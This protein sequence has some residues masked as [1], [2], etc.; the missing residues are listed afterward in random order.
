[1]PPVHRKAQLQKDRRQHPPSLGSVTIETSESHQDRDEDRHSLE[2]GYQIR[3][4]TLTQK[5]HPTESLRLSY[6]PSTPESLPSTPP[7]IPEHMVIQFGNK[8]M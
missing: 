2:R 5:T 3:G 7:P 8:A 4:S 1:M 6:T